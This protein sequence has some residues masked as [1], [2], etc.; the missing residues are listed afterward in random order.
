MTTACNLTIII[1][2]RERCYWWCSTEAIFSCV[3][4][5]EVAL[6]REKEV[7]MWTPEVNKDNKSKRGATKFRGWG[8]GCHSSRVVLNSLWNNEMVYLIDCLCVIKLVLTLS[9]SS[10]W[11]IEWINVQAAYLTCMISGQL[12]IK[13]EHKK[14]KKATRIKNKRATCWQTSCEKVSPMLSGTPRLDGKARFLMPKEGSWPIKICT[15][16]T[17]ESKPAK[18]SMPVFFKFWRL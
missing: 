7:N 8:G 5:G 1:L 17:K 3:N 13:T 14:I 16:E 2:R 10:D 12:T 6:C 18:W 9:D 11:L 4:F 15:Y